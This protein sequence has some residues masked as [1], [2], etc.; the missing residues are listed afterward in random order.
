MQKY[1]K[2]SNRT[3]F[4]FFFKKYFKKQTINVIFISS[5]TALHDSLG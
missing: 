4:S 1:E 3:N 5:E 2:I